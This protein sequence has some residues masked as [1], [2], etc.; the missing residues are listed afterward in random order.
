ML[1]TIQDGTLSGEAAERIKNLVVPPQDRERVR[2]VIWP[3]S[4]T[5]KLMEQETLLA[6]THCQRDLVHFVCSS[7]IVRGLTVR[8]RISADWYLLS[9]DDYFVEY[10]AKENSQVSIITRM[11]IGSKA[12]LKA[13]LDISPE[14]REI[15]T[16]GGIKLYGPDQLDQ[17]TD[18]DKSA[19]AM[20]RMFEYYAFSPYTSYR[21]RPT[22]QQAMNGNPTKKKFTAIQI[23]NLRIPKR[24]D[25][26]QKGTGKKL[27]E[28]I[29]VTEHMRR[30]PTKNGIKLIKIAE[31]LRG[32]IDA[33]LKPK[34][35]KVYKVVK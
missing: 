9:I 12:S 3:F 16:K 29:S 25:D 13:C 23:V 20:A 30:Q 34:T 33:P 6:V 19:W 35:K 10:G 22:F 15:I 7:Q 21:E 4:T 32:P 2:P 31:H 17:M 27:T 28:R 14:N 1:H 11:L 26:A 18:D 5:D 24:R 8:P